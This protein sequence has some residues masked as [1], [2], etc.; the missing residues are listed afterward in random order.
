MRPVLLLASILALLA[1]TAD[2][3]TIGV[4]MPKFDDKFLSVLRHGIEDYAATIPD[5]KLMIEDAKGDANT[6]LEN[7]KAMVAAKVDA[8]IVGPAD[9][10]FGPQMSKIASDAGIPLV[11][12]NNQPANLDDLP[13]KQSFVASDERESGTLET[14]EI[15]R[16]LNGK[17]KVVVMMGELFH[18]AAR[19]RT[20]DVHDVLATEP[21]KGITIAEQQSANW[22]RDQADSQMQ[23]WLSAGVKF[24]AVIANNDEMALGAIRAMKRAGLSTTDIAV[25]GVDATDDALAAMAAG[26]LRVTVLQNAAGQGKGAVDTAVKLMA[27]EK[28]DKVVYV[29]FELVTPAN[30]QNYLPKS[31]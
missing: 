7:M 14:K 5:I 9:G 21:C 10:D 2:A 15:C 6:Q 26:D 4:A 19:R 23:E 13:E 3:K 25:G 16:V 27:G 17:G 12:V 20:Q 18:A 1:Q 24:D 31:Q 30:L 22:S 28:V 29:P 11:Y 8:I